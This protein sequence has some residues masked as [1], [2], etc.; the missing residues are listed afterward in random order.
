MENEKNLVIIDA[1]HG[2]EDPGAIGKNG[3]YEK[4]LN[5]EIANLVGKSFLR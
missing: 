2:G 3:I 1:G 4:N 5:L